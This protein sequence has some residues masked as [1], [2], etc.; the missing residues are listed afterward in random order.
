M[1]NKQ[2]TGLMVIDIQGKLATLVH[3]SEALISQTH[4][5]LKSAK[6]LGLPIMAVE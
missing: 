6:T 3:D 1:L 2:T 5:L 4:T